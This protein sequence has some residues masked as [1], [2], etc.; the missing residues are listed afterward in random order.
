MAQV[1][2]LSIAASGVLL[3]KSLGSLASLERALASTAKGAG[4]GAVEGFVVENT[5]EA[6]TNAGQTVIKPL[7]LGTRFYVSSDGQILDANTYFRNSGFRAGVRDEVWGN[8]VEGATGLVKDP[9][10][11]NVMNKAEPWDMGHR[12]GVEYW[13]ERDNAINKWLDNRDYTTRKEFLDQMNDPSRYRPELPSSNRSHRAE[14]V[15]NLFW[16]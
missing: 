1:E 16:N 8:A 13:K 15:S 7:N 3:G 10:S 2:A 11:D 14:D 6:A 12:P 9:M 5:T 4:Y